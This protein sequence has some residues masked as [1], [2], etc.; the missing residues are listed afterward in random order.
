MTNYNR[1]GAI[2]TVK[3]PSRVT[4]VRATPAGANAKYTSLAGITRTE[5]N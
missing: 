5:A 3:T 4:L 1:A 2:Q